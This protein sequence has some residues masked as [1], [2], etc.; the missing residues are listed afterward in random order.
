[1]EYSEL[2]QIYREQIDTLDKEIIYLFSRR[3]Q[4]VKQIWILKKE[5]N[6][7]ILQ[8][9][10]WEKLLNE[11]IEVW[12]DLMVPEQFIRDIWEKIHKE[13]LKLEKEI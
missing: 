6:A 9:D 3:F 10:R 13:S 7:V 4:I 5:N 12:K 2:L 8:K 1:M 11:N